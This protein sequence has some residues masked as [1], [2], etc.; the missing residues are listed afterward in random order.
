MGS[1]DEYRSAWYRDY[2][3]AAERAAAAWHRARELGYRKALTRLGD[4][5]WYWHLFHGEERVNGGLSPTREDALADA[6]F[7]ISRHIWQAG[8]SPVTSCG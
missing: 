3:E 8:N 4:G 6:G 2:E 7:A 1:P 5:T